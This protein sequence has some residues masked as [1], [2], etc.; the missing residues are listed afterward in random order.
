MMPWLRRP[1]EGELG[2]GVP[3]GGEEGAPA[4]S[5]QAHVSTTHASTKHVPTTHAHA[6]V[7]GTAG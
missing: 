1:K 2:A 7:K 4:C 6:R 5:R 3:P